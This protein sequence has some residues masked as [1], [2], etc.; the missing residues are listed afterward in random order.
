MKQDEH[1]PIM[2]THAHEMLSK[3]V[4]HLISKPKKLFL[5]DSL[6]ALTTAFLL[7]VVLRNFHA[8]VG[9]PKIILTYLSLLAAF[10]C[11]YSVTCFFLIKENWAPYIK[12]LSIAN[13]L[14]CL[15]TLCLIFFYS[16][17][18]KIFGILYFLAELLIISGLIY[19]EQKVMKDIKKSAKN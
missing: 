2:L 15:L 17:R 3:L 18:L 4:E 16:P 5:V 8:Y 14:Y 10:P 12:G 13:A 11:I 1:S 7:F 9:M 6:G 19:I